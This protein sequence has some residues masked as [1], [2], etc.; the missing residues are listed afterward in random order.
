MLDAVRAAAPRCG[1]S[2]WDGMLIARVLAPDSAA[3]RAAVV[4]ILHVM[5]RDR[6]LPRVWLC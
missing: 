1:A 5:R 6:T 3:L 4:D 2:A